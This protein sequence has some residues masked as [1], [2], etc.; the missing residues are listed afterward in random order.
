MEEMGIEQRTVGQ[1]GFEM[2]APNRKEQWF[3]RGRKLLQEMG[4]GTNGRGMLENS[5]FV[6]R[7]N[8]HKLV[9]FWGRAG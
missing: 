3:L 1:R 4:V 7:I 2:M 9:L 5:A 8:D 6:S